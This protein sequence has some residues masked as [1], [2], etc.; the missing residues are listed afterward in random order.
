VKSLSPDFVENPLRSKLSDTSRRKSFS[1]SQLLNPSSEST[2][3]ITFPEEDNAQYENC[4]KALDKLSLEKLRESVNLKPEYEETQLFNS[5]KFVKVKCDQVSN[6]L[7]ILD[8][9][10]S[11]ENVR[12]KCDR[13][14]TMF[15]NGHDDALSDSSD[16]D[17]PFWKNSFDG[18]YFTGDPLYRRRKNTASVELVQYVKGVER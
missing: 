18:G 13:K 10:S 6:K 2:K 11:Q 3:L 7:T 17:P 4:R 15:F 5:N 12:N 8:G 16:E 1:S 14:Q 9:C